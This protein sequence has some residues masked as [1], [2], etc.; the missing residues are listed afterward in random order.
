M[1]I[2]PEQRDAAIKSLAAHAAYLHKLRA[3]IAAIT[4]HAT[5]LGWI[6]AAEGSVGSARV[7]FEAWA[8][9]MAGGTPGMKR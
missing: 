4:P 3:R 8:N 7:H 1:H 5:V 2:T 9:D 6:S